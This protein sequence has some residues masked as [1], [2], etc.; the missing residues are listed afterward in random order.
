[1]PVKCA[2]CKNDKGNVV[3]RQNGKRMCDDCY[4]ACVA[5]LLDENEMQEKAMTQECVISTVLCF[6]KCKISMLTTDTLVQ[7]CCDKFAEDDIV[8]AQSLM[9]R[10]SGS[11]DR[12]Q[13]RRGSDMATKAMTDIIRWLHEADIKQMPTIVTDNINILPSVD[14]GNIDVS[15]LMGE[16]SRMRHENGQ[17]K[18]MCE[19]VVHEC[20]RTIHE[21]KNHAH[22]VLCTVKN[23]MEEKMR[24]M[25]EMIDDIKAAH[26][27]IDQTIGNTTEDSVTLAKQVVGQFE[28]HDNISVLPR[29]PEDGGD[30]YSAKGS[31]TVDGEDTM[32]VWPH[33]V[34]REAPLPQRDP[35]ARYALHQPEVKACN[36]S[37]AMKQTIDTRVVEETRMVASSTPQCGGEIQ[38]NWVEDEQTPFAEVVK[39]RPVSRGDAGDC[40]SNAPPHPRSPRGNAVTHNGA[41]V[42]RIGLRAA[43]PR[44]S[45]TD[46]FISRLDRFTTSMEI[47]EHLNSLDIEVLQIDALE[48]RHD[49]YTSFKVKVISSMFRR[50]MEPNMWPPRVYVR[51]Y[52]PPRGITS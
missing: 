49:S 45:T 6:A 51:K 31:Y 29:H 17:F 11:N 33:L 25:S 36:A 47:R 8:I 3:K 1:M 52:Y 35:S 28:Q 22:E 46:V 34:L 16:I 42:K 32:Q 15:L 27:T 39:R 9:H 18:E 40:P 26:V 48:T 13:I 30:G 50:I 19:D 44:V 37:H 21:V 24:N 41:R 23:E 43:P 14:V 12:L 10:L 2:V 20:T 38:M 7:L 5:K 4:H